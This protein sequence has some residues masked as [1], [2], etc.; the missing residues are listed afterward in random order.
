[1]ILSRTDQLLE[2]NQT[3]SV[4]NKILGDA[5]G[6][7]GLARL[8]GLDRAIQGVETGDGAALGVGAAAWGGEPDTVSG[9][10]P[11]S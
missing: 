5:A 7:D 4:P 9:S 8:P 3:K 10:V 1:M 6:T 2:I 11:R